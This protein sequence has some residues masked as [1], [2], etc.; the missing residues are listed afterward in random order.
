MANYC[1]IHWSWDFERVDFQFL[2]IFVALDNLALFY[3]G[4]IPQSSFGRI[5]KQS[6]L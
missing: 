3:R 5:I 2:T 6:V 1:W 4:W